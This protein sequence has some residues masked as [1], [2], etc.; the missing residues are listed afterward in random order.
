PITVFGDGEQTRDFVNVTDVVQANIKAAMAVG[1]SGAFN[2]A[3]ATQITINDLVRALAEVSGITPEV[4]Y[5]PVRPGDVLHSRADITA[6]REAFG[7]EPAADIREGLTAYMA[8][9]AEESRAQASA[10]VG[11]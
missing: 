1:V 6:A 7:F 5:G 10:A 9:A 11:S 3:S 8:W 4:Q 2:C